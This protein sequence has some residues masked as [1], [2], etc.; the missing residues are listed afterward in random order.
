MATYQKC[1]KEVREMALELMTKFESHTPLLEIKVMLDFVFALADRDED[2]KMKGPAIV[3]KGFRVYGQA[4]I[5][6]LKDRALGHGDAEILLDGDW[7]DEDST[8]EQ[9]RALLDHEL[10]HI[11]AKKVKGQY[12]YDDLGRP[13]L[14]LR[15]HDVEVGW[16]KLIAERHGEH[17]LEQRQAKMIM[18]GS[19]QYFWPLLAQSSAV[20]TTKKK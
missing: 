13:L 8:E 16:F 1:P 17:S 9:Q 4:K 12:V 5:V 3:R 19:G 14:R 18:D 15:N 2:G 20:T 7:W 6:T 11:A 10:H